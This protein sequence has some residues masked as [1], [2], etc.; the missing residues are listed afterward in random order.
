LLE[1]Q[2]NLSDK[3]DVLDREVVLWPL[4]LNRGNSG[5]IT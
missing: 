5:A 4:L 1:N 2:D 3:V